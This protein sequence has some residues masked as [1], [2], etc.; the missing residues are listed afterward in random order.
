MRPRR[1]IEAQPE[2]SLSS[3]GNLG[4]WIEIAGPQQAGGL[5]MA[6]IQAAMATVLGG[7]GK[8]IAT[9]MAA[10]GLLAV[11]YRH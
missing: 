8:I 11:D 9:D 3:G 1:L 10:T 6:W 2:F 5:P 4:H 7:D